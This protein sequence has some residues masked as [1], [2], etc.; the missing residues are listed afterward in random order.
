MSVYANVYVSHVY[1]VAWVS[2]ELHD[3][4]SG[5]RA[6]FYSTSSTLYAF[7]CFSRLRRAKYV[8]GVSIGGDKC[9]GVSGVTFFRGSVLVQSA[10]TSLIIG[11][12]ARTL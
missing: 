9:I 5:L 11:E 3:L 2:P 8:E 7:E 1:S 12:D 10:V 4:G 6:L